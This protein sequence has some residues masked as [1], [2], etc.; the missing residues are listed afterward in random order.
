MTN[1]LPAYL[2][3]GVPEEKFWD[4]S[5]KELKP[6][7]IAYRLNMKA[8]DAESWRLGM[9]VM[10]AMS[11]VMANAFS[12][13]SKAQ[14]LKKPFLSDMEEE[15]HEPTEEEMKMERDRLLSTLMIM[16]DN[17]ERKNQ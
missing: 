1:I 3:I 11:T 7:T 15:Y 17:F 2:A 10:N 6:Y 8:K 9:Y 16:K 12:K 5:P 14:Y 13:N 4:S